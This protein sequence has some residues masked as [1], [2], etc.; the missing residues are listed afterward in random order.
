ME[1]SKAMNKPKLSSNLIEAANRAE[2]SA[3]LI[4]EGYKVYRPE[5]DDGGEDLVLSR[6]SGDLVAVQLKGRL[7]VERGKYSGRG[8]W[9]LF[10]CSPWNEGAS[11]AWFLIPHDTLFEYMEERHG[12]AAGFAE[13]KWSV[14]KPS[15]EAREFL[16][17]YEIK[18]S[19]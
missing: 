7:H 16:E 10:P 9:M 11:R 5:A 8:I 1:F 17:P 3:I 4:R 18:L 12:H 14:R 2:V 19:D 13:G 6:P 15:K